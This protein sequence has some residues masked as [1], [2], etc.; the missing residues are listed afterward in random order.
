MADFRFAPN[1]LAEITQ[2]EASC[3]PR[4]ATLLDEAL[5]KITTDPALPGRF[6]SFYDPAKPSFLYRADPFMIHFCI[7]DDSSVEFLNVFW[8]Q[9]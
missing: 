3:S 2:I 5:A 6:P 8:Q 4:E 1:C 9:V 7:N